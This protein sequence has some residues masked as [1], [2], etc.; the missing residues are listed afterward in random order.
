MAMTIE[1]SVDP[2]ANTDLTIF[3]LYSDADG[4]TVPFAVGVPITDLWPAPGRIFYNVPDGTVDV[5]CY[6]HYYNYYYI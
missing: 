1:I 3:D 6:K 5:C 2:G 4:Y